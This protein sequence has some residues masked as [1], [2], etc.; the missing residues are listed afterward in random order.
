[1]VR[2]KRKP[3]GLHT[4][5]S[6][7]ID[8]VSDHC[9]GMCIIGASTLLTPFEGLR[10]RRARSCFT[11]TSLTASSLTSNGNTTFGD[12]VTFFGMG[13]TYVNGVGSTDTFGDNAGVVDN[14]AVTNNGTLEFNGSGFLT[15]DANDDDAL[16]V[17]NSATGTINMNDLDTSNDDVLTVAAGG[18]DTAFENQGAINLNG[19][20]LD[21]TGVTAL[22]TTGAGVVDMGGGTIVGDVVNESTAQ[23]S[24]SGTIGDG[25]DGSG[26]YTQQTAA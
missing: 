6:V 14:G 17:T 15:A 7:G 12:G 24:L 18:A 13:N 5:R 8:S 20:T 16:T 9:L 19:Q 25:T 1:M 11:R 22:N 23:Q 4:G 2:G 21:V 10:T 3:V 26:S